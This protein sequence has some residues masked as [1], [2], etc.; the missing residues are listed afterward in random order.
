MI[1][2]GVVGLN[3][4]MSK[5]IIEE[6]NKHPDCNLSGALVRSKSIYSNIAQYED[7]LELAKISDAI[8]DFSNP[9]TSIELAKKLAHN[10]IP[11]ICGT[12][13]FTNEEFLELKQAAQNLPIIWS[14]NM[15]VGVN[16]LEKLLK[17]AASKLN[18]DFDSAIIDIHHRHKKD[19]PSGTALMLA[20]TIEETNPTHQVQISSLR[21]GEVPGDHQIIFS[22]DNESISLSHQAYN[23]NIFASGAI[24]ACLW[25]QNRQNGLYSMQDVLN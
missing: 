17:L 25:A 23:R 11:I 8:I 4:R 9:T 24:K 14:A 3:G 21:I 22:S 16:L 2:I 6:I 1:K 7:I 10:N 19:A 5:V 18:N 12:T 20:K 13:G 15:S